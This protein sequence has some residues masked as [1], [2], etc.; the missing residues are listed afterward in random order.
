MKFM[1]AAILLSVALTGCATSD[2]MARDR[3]KNA[4][5]IVAEQRMQDGALNGY[6]QRLQKIAYERTYADCVRWNMAHGVAY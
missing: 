6:D 5:S 3:P 4:C 1:P 2:D